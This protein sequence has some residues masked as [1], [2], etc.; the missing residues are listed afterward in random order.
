MT[1]RALTVASCIGLVAVFA[2]AG[3]GAAPGAP[4]TVPAA[5]TD[6]GT[7]LAAW[8][9]RALPPGARLTVGDTASRVVLAL[10]GVAATV[11]PPAA[12]PHGTTLFRVSADTAPSLDVRALS[13][14]LTAV[15]VARFGSAGSSYVVDAV[16]TGPV[17]RVGAEVAE[18]AARRA[19]A[20]SGL[21]ANPAVTVCA[22]C[23]P[24]LTAGG[25]DLRA[26]SLVAVL[27]A[28][29]PVSVRAVVA[30]PAETRAGRPARTVVVGAV[31]PGTV[32]AVAGA[33]AGTYRPT[34]TAVTTTTT[35]LTWPL[36]ATS[37]LTGV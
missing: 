16:V 25:L 6:P 10:A 14:A 4:R 17:A 35:T 15:P 27:A 31:A 30:D 37:T 21:L 33:T 9:A 20:G 11:S 2:T 36:T 23:T 3:C 7:L 13:S 5:A 12:A 29:G 28:L 18:D 24:G 1:I 19:A 26:A 8:A 34:I 22:A 32:R